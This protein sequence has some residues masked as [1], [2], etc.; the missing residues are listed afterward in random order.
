MNGIYSGLSAAISAFCRS[1]I[2]FP[3]RWGKATATAIAVMAV[4][5][6]AP[7][8]L[9]GPLMDKAKA[10]Q[11]IKIA[12]ISGMPWCGLNDSNEP[13][14]FA[15]KITVGV[16]KTMGISNIDPVM[17]P[18]WSGLIPG[19][20]ARQFDIISCGM[21]ITKERC[22]NVA[23]SDPLGVFADPF[24]V[25]K[26][27]PKQLLSYADIKKT[28]ARMVATTGFSDVTQAENFAGISPSQI[29]TVPSR[30]EVLAAMMSGRADVAPYTYFEGIEMVAKSDGKLELTNP[31]YLEKWGKNW[32]AS[33]FRKEDKDFVDA[34][35]AA[36]KK[37]LGSKEMMS[38][39]AEDGYT[40]EF[41]PEGNVDVNWVCE[42]R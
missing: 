18:Q 5:A 21:Y 33:A 24:I 36:Q 42:N 34:Y 37:Y 6:A 25:P 30:N 7:Q 40:E 26:G 10:G 4:L 29:M 31:K 9:A 1:A 15:N 22:N 14:G 8:A 39:V 2:A 32:G 35:N 3:A 17:L 16:L 13:I 12:F 27:N 28:G 20:M 23:F 38:A 19:L 11:P 41:L